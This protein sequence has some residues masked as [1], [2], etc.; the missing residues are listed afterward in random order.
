MK[1][2]ITSAMVKLVEKIEESTLDFIGPH[3]VR[4]NDGARKKCGDQLS[5][6]PAEYGPQLRGVAFEEKGGYM[7]KLLMMSA[8]M[9]LAETIEDLTSDVI[10]SAWCPT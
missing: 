2:L 6:R 1:S 4:P 3:C 10:G 8:M 9:K 7:V 5:S